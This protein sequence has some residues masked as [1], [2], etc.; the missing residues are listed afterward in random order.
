MNRNIENVVNI[1]ESE[2]FIQRG[3]CIWYYII[4][5]SECIWCCLLVD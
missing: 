3:D 2:Y 1:G 5:N 4:K